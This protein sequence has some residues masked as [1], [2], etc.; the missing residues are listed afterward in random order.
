MGSV[1]GICKLQILKGAGS[2]KSVRMP[3]RSCK[4]PGKLICGCLLGDLNLPQNGAGSTGRCNTS[5]K[6]TCRSLKTQGLSGSLI[7]TQRDLVEMGLRVDG[8]VGPLW[9]VLS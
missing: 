7:Q 6:F 1:S 4:S 9:E 3:K 5:L 8:Q 2:A